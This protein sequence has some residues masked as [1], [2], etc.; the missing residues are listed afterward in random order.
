[1]PDVYDRE[2]R[3]RIMRRIRKTDTKPELSVR[4][5]LHGKGYRFRL[6][7]ADLPGTPDIVLP[8]HRTVVLVHGC[9]WH[10]HSCPLGKKPKSNLSYW[11]PKLRR[12]I[13]RDAN[14]RAALLDQGWKVITIWE[15]ETQDA[16]AL[17]H[18]LA[19]IG[20]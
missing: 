15:C 13:E 7:R 14:N 10:Q 2:V 19:S 18:K 4:R 11:L 17:E 1:M 8:K 3:S 6:H 12:N 5:F 16:E 9:F 20:G